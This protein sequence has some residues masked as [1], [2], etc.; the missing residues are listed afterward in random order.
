MGNKFNKTESSILQG[1]KEAVAYAEGKGGVAKTHKIRVPEIDVRK[2]RKR[3]GLSQDKFADAFGVSAATI[4]NWEQKRRT[5]Q[6]AAK[7]LLNVIY[8]NPDAVLNAIGDTQ[9]P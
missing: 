5:P 6:G 1:L 4:R 2:A 3:L 8:T 9:L 7:V